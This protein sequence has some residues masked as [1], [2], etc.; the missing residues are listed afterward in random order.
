MNSMQLSSRRFGSGES[1]L[2]LHGLLGSGRNWQAIGKALASD[3]EVFAIDLRNHGDSPWSDEMTYPAMA[4]DILRLL[5][6]LGIGQ[7]T[8]VGHSMGGK[9]AM[10]A[11]LAYPDRIRRFGVVDIAPVAYDHGH[12]FQAYLET[13]LS[14]DLASMSRRADVEA[15]LAATIPEAP[16]RAFLAQNSAPG[17]AGL[18]WRSNLRALLDSLPA[19]TGWPE[20]VAGA[21]YEGPTLFLRGGASGYVQDSAMGEIRRLFPDSDFETIDGVGHWVHAEAPRATI[22]AL[23]RLLARD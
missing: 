18:V 21:V 14:L 12:G 15:A 13:M 8:L 23:R 4:G 5:D 6:D 2:I 16:I 19:I 11:A 20:P 22:E 1:V 17:E 3:V 7:A 9:V 10:C